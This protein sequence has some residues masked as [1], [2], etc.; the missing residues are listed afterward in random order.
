MEPYTQP[1]FYQQ[2]LVIASPPSQ[3]IE[4]LGLELCDLK[5]KS[6]DKCNT[7]DSL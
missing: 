6:K 3:M 1:G 4:S 7:G 2:Q 5:V